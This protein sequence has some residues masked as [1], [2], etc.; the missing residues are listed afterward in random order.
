MGIELLHLSGIGPW[1]IDVRKIGT[2]C[3]PSEPLAT[4]HGGLHNDTS[5][6]LDD[7]LMSARERKKELLPFSDC[8]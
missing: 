5:L 6:K 4:L 3:H 7:L 8:D 2:R 1:L